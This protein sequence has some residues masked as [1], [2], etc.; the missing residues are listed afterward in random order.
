MKPEPLQ[1]SD[2]ILQRALELHPENRRAFLDQACAGDEALRQK[3]ESLLAAAQQLD[4]FMQERMSRVAGELM[5]DGPM[6][7]AAG[8][9]IGHYKIVELLDKGGMGEVYLAT[10]T[11]SGREV[12]LKLLPDSSISDEQRV[13]R[14]QQEAR[15]ILALNHP[16]IVTIYEI[17]QTDSAHYIVTE[18]VTGETLRRRLSHAPLEIP[19]ALAIAIEVAKALEA[20]HAAGIVH[21]DIKPENIMLRPDGYVKVLDFGVAKLTE[22]AAPKVRKFSTIS[23]LRESSCSP[24]H[25]TPG[26]MSA[27]HSGQYARLIMSSEVGAID[28]NR[29]RWSGTARSVGGSGEPP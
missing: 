11:R 17:G 22:R 29:P 25:T 19:E 10:D 14:F 15:S 4:R 24:N 20:T 1:R 6:T 16:N 5:M 28:L 3:V 2:E 8:Q 26:R 23:T 9:I 27:S 7:A 21:R 12:A 18:R 13:R